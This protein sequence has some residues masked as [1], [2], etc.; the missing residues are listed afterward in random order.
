MQP[1]NILE[2]HKL[3]KYFPVEKGLFKKVVGFVRA[4]DNITVSIKSGEVLGIVGES[5]SGKTTLGKCIL[6]A[7][8][9]TNG[10]ILFRGDAGNITDIPTLNKKELRRL[11][12]E[13]NMIFQDPFSSLSPRMTV[14]QII[15]E[16]LVMHQYRKTEIE[17]RV[18]YL[19]QKVG[20][21]ISHL[22][23]YPNSF[24]GGQR[25][26]IGIARALA[27]NPRLIVADEPVSALDVS[28]QAQI[29]NLLQELKDELNLTYLFISHNLSVIEHISDRVIVMYVGRIVESGSTDQIYSRP[30]HPYTRALL[31]ALPPPNPGSNFQPE[32]LL[33]EVANPANP[34]SGCHFHP[35]CSQATEYCSMNKPELRDLGNNHYSACFFSEE[36]S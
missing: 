20:L 4:V 21:Q 1:E 16:P 29:L 3:S 25:Q 8:E 34:P 26:R 31:S 23:R 24:S 35:R 6:K 27:T 9:I 32:I 7:T 22:N 18:K 11:R 5:G 2:V 10:K 19:I 17:D 12:K 15:S 36:L 13:I 28:I 30:Q 33:G 14:N